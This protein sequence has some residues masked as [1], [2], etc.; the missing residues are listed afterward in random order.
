MS[1]C[2]G[3]SNNFFE[4]LGNF[5][6]NTATQAL[7][8]GFASFEN[9]QFGMNGLTTQGLK[10]ITGAAAAEEANKQARQQME[11]TRADAAAAR[12]EQQNQNQR[13]QLAQSNAAGASRARSRST[14]NLG[15]TERDYLGL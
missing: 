12:V 13:N 7:T 14:S 15:S 8:G 11:Q 5:T 10:Q 9:G 6:L 2:D 3:G 4:E 1:S